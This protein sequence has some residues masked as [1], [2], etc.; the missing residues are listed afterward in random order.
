MRIVVHYLVAFW[1]ATLAP[2]GWRTDSPVPY[3]DPTACSLLTQSEVVAVLGPKMGPGTPVA[4]TLCSWVEEG[5]PD[6][7]KTTLWLHTLTLQVYANNKAPSAAATQTPVSGLG[8]EAFYLT[9]SAAG[10]TQLYVKK[11]A[12]AFDLRVASTLT[13]AQKQ[14][15][16][17]TLAR[18]V[19]TKM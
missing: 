7:Q 12:A 15:M 10:E 19:L 2:M 8:N 11:G 18:D 1:L 5:V 4:P 17:A 3:S 13:I 16:E 9:R 6:L 14:S